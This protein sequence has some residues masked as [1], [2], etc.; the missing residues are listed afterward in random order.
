MWRR[1]VLMTYN[2][3]ILLDIAQKSRRNDGTLNIYGP[4]N[5]C[6]KQALFLDWLRNLV[7]T[8]P[9]LDT[10][11]TNYCMTHTTHYA[12]SLSPSILRSIPCGTM[13][14]IRTGNEYVKLKLT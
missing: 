10:I 3:I 8:A 9:V 4:T 6:S 7:R 12:S 5:H 2:T 14:C 13:A 11:A 1:F